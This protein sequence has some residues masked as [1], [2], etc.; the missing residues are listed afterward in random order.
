MS[1][2][3]NKQIV[4][5]AYDALAAGDAAG[6]FAA[7]HDDVVMTYVGSYSMA[8]T[9]HGKADF[10]ARFVPRLREVLKGAIRMQVTDAVAEGDTVVV[11]ARG[12]A[13]TRD[14]R[15]YNNNYTIWLKLKDGK[16]VALREY[17]DTALTTSIFG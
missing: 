12:E 17:M 2:A 1:A 6:Y 15:P 3:E 7:M 4:L 16:I 14:G 8:G 11:E 9:Y 5:A 13:H 10:T